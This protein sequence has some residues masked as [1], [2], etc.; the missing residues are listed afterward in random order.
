M[1]KMIA[2]CGLTCRTCPIY[3]VTRE[4]DKK[5]QKEKREEILQ[6]LKENYGQNYRLEDITDCDGC[7]A[8]TGRLFRACKDCTI[9]KCAKQKRIESCAYCEE[10]ICQTLED[11][12]AR[13]PDA[14][15]RLD[16]MRDALHL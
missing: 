6:F 4:Q 10:Y 9:R 12:F 14:K 13:E 3:L 11:F 2:Y 7:M 1:N 5:K 15:K 16:E 8:D